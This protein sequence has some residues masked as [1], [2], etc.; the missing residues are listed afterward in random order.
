MTS[1]KSAAAHCYAEQW[2][3]VKNNVY[4]EGSNMQEANIYCLGVAKV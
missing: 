3:V 1:Q 4:A 2:L